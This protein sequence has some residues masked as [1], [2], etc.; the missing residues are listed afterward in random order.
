MWI[1]AS[2]HP[3]SPY[4]KHAQSHRAEP[5]GPA[6][7]MMHF[8]NQ[9]DQIFEPA[10]Q[11]RKDEPLENEDKTKPEKNELQS[12]APSLFAARRQYPGGVDA[13]P[14]QILEK[15]AVGRNDQR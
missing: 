1:E 15:L 5:D 2:G 13:G 7:I 12:P 6:R 9:P 8:G 11:E 14:F 4:Q 3:G 10:R